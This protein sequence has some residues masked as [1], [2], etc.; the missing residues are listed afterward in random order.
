MGVHTKEEREEEGGEGKGAEQGR[1]HTGQSI[2]T[3]SCTPGL[4]LSTHTRAN[5]R[6]RKR[7]SP[8]VELDFGCVLVV[9]WVLL[10]VVWV[11]RGV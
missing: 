1:S 7:E 2:V 6:A 8:R 9:V 10:W 5:K 11:R 3:H 4:S